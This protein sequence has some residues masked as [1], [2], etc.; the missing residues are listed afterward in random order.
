MDTAD[1]VI[2]GAGIIGLSLAIELART[3][4]RVVIVDRRQAM[5]E[6]SWAAAGMLAARD[7]ENP[8]ALA[9]L[10]QLS[11]RLYAEFLHR[12]QELSGMQVPL[13]S[14]C[15]LQGTRSGET[16]LVASGSNAVGEAEPLSTGELHSLAPD[17]VPG[18]RQFLRLAEDS[19]DPRDLCR[20]L[21]RAAVSAGAR[22]IEGSAV[23]STRDT[24][25][26]VDVETSSGNIS[27]GAFVN[28]C[29]AWAAGLLPGPGGELGE[30]VFPRKGQIV[31]VRL[32]QGDALSFVLRTPE[33]YLVPRGERRVVIGATVEDAGYDKSLDP[34]AIRLLI[35]MASALWPAVSSGVVLES[36]AGL[37][38][39]TADGLPVLG[40]ATFAKRHWI[41]SGHFRNGILLAPAT[42]HI[43]SQLLQG[44]E[45]EIDVAPFAAQR[46]LR[47]TA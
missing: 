16:F 10:A 19:I 20:A 13:R 35:E 30:A 44:T 31:S 25:T 43:L 4:L 28:C 47:S 2:A 27:A 39:A 24:L 33:I 37:R 11:L 23:V 40:K 29:G 38:P 21:P 45:P 12:V 3:G 17:L 8:P 41:A 7:P 42:A 26:G 34:K 32:P 18:G 36:W 15:V 14:S 46:L 1:V 9:P 22:L 6:S 5:Q